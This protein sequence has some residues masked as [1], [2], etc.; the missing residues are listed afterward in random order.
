MIFFFLKA[1]F[2]PGPAPSAQIY[3]NSTLPELP[4]VPDTLPASSFGANANTSDDIDFDDLSRRFEDL[5]K[6]T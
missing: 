6:K 2:S 5:K 1:V 4:S 3:D